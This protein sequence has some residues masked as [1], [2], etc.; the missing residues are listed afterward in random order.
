MLGSIAIFTVYFNCKYIAVARTMSYR[1]QPFFGEIVLSSFSGQRTLGSVAWFALF[2]AIIFALLGVV[3]WHMPLNHDYLIVFWK[4]G[5]SYIACFN[6]WA[7]MMLYKF[8]HWK[9]GSEDP[10]SFDKLS[11]AI[12]SQSIKEIG[13]FPNGNDLLSRIVV[14]TNILFLLGCLVGAIYLITQ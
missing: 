6:A 4:L 7:R 1:R 2:L 3:A 11:F 12:L 13:W 14:L 8:S 5:A 10:V 9:E